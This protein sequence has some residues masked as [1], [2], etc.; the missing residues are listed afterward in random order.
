MSKIILSTDVK[1]ALGPMKVE[2][3]YTINVVQISK[4]LE[5]IRACLDDVDNQEPFAL[6]SD[7]SVIVFVPAVFGAAWYSKTIVKTPMKF[8]TP[9]EMAMCIQTYLYTHL[10][11]MGP[12]ETALFVQ[13]AQ[14][15]INERDNPKPLFPATLMPDHPE[16][17]GQVGT[18]QKGAH[19]RRRNR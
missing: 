1:S 18:S 19:T 13:T 8:N 2:S 17:T 5:K 12:L 11:F 10:K 14:K 7:D 9:A 3:T 16:P 15:H 4:N 6:A